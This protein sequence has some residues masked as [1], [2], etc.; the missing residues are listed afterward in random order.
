MI[1]TS[2]L[3]ILLAATLLVAGCSTGH[4]G[5]TNRMGTVRSTLYAPP[6]DVAKAAEEVLQEMNIPI[7]TAASTAIDGKV[8]GETARDKKITITV[9]LHGADA[10]VVSI[11]HGTIG[12]ENISVTI[13][14]R[15]EAK[16]GTPRPSVTDTADTYPTQ[17]APSADT[18]EMK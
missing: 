2:T 8:V 4:P 1:K 14:G 17:A 3:A 11:R 12:D 15:I 5:A 18:A 7:I 13:L 10:S 9:E 6:A 16:L